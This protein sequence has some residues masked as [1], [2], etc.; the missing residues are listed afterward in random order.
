[1]RKKVIALTAAVVMLAVLGLTGCETGPRFIKQADFDET[2]GIV[3]TFAGPVDADWAADKANFSVNEKPDPDILLN[4]ESVRLDPGNTRL[5]LT[6]ADALNQ[7][8]PHQVVVK[9]IMADG[10]P[11][12]ST[13]VT[14]ARSYFGHLFA[15]FLGALLI[16]NFVFSKYLGLCVFFGTSQKKSTAVGMGITFTFVIV[17]ASLMSW[18]LYQFVLKPYR[19]DH[20]QIIVFIGLVSLTVQ[21][22]D[23]ILRKINPALFKAFGVYLVLVIANCIVIAVPLILADNEYNMF[24][25]LMLALG[26]GLGFLL[27]LFLMS[28]VRERLEFANVPVS[29]R[30]LPIAFI[31][32][33]L[34]ALSFMG[35]SGMSIF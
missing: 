4:I 27:A 15:I 3:L 6:L 21:A 12:G 8:Q 18:F 16:Q 20:L 1:M 19:L 25:S 17:F 10:K 2:H 7:E 9:D 5:T 23:T 32:A 33:G 31:V 22:V 35:F 26:A 34:F 30:G 24:E 28:S 13:A 14:V 11:L 29:Y